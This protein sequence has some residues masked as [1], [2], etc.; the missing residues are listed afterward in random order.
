MINPSF[1]VTSMSQAGIDFYTGVPDSLLSS[2]CAF[3]EDNFDKRHHVVAAN[4]GNAIALAAGYHMATGNVPCI[5]LQN[6]GL[7]NIINPLISLADPSVY[8]LPSLL[9]IGWRGSPGTI[10]EPQHIRQG[11]LTPS[12]LDTLEIPHFCLP[13]D[14]NHAAALIAE[15]ARL[16]K[17]ENRPVAILVK[18]NTFVPLQSSEHKSHANMSREYAIEII[19][20]FLSDT[21]A[22]V[23]T[24][25]KA[26]RELYEIRERQNCTHK[27][28]FLVVGSMGHASQIA[29]GIALSKPSKRVICL[30][31]DGAMLM[32]MGALAIN[33]C[34]P[35]PNFRHIVLNNGAH[36]S[37]GG[38]PTV[39]CRISVEQIAKGCGY[40]NIASAHDADTLR[41]ILP[42]FMASDG[43]ALMNV[44]IKTGARTDLIRPTATP[45]ECKKIFMECIHSKT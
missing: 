1:F 14:E 30:D 4:E 12:L 32:H 11:E 28:D 16:A 13:T 8:S 15:A 6:S 33:G 29:A 17:T 5:Y 10:D 25:G 18:K 44:F 27:T 42:D 2:L 38:I 9:L 34:L 26:S 45:A 22:I 7:G 41:T 35:I 37:V 39:A 21:D 24:T 43:P 36:D 31:G 20:S 40:V 19:T 3:I 23:S